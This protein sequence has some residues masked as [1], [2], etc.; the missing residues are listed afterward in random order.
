M[1]LRPE[2]RVVAR[3]LDGQILRGTTLD[4]SPLREAFR[5]NDGA[6]THEVAI[7]KLKAVFFVRDFA[8]DPAYDEK[9]GFHARQ[10]HGKK[11][12]VEF[13]DG[14]TLYGYTLNYSSRGLGFFMFPGD[15]GSNNEKVFVV[16]AATRSVKLSSL[17]G[18]F[19]STPTA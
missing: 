12:L 1:N 18:V 2:L 5:L 7:S 13:A 8:G 17:T 14:E 4:F 19:P 16:H 6:T 11:V 15:P 9:K 10:N 3:F